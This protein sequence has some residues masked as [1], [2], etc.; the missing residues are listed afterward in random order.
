MPAARGQK[1]NESD[2]TKIKNYCAVLF[3]AILIGLQY[4]EIKV[5]EY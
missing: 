1:F 5:Y 4:N 3:S 2:N